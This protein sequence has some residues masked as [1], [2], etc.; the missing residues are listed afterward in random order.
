MGNIV[1]SGTGVFTPSQNLTNEALVAGYNAHVDLWNA[2]H[3]EEIAAGEMTAKEHS[4]EAFIEKASGIKNRY[5]MEASGLEEP[6]R[7]Y[8]YLS[9]L[10]E[11]ELASTP[12]QVKMALAAAKAALSEAGLDGSDIDM[13]IIS[14]S[15][16]ERFVP[17]MATE[18]QQILGANGFAFDMAMGCSSATFGMSTAQDALISGMAN[19]ALVVTAEYLSPLMAYED[20][21]GHFI[22]GDAAVAMILEREEEASSDAAFR[23]LDRK[24]FTEFSTNIQAGFGSRVLIE[25]DKISD[26]AQRFSQSGRVVFKELL[27]KVIDH[28]ESHLGANEKAVSDFKRMW[29]HQA[30]INMNLFASRKIL[31][32]EPSQ[33]EAPTILDQYANTAGAGCMIAFNNH[34]SDFESGDLG[35]I[36]S[37]GASYSIGSF[38]VEKV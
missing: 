12:V 21:D 37:F 33:D 8:P 7:M 32:H 4:S 3:A 2:E 23:I 34:K 18:L 28:V 10:A 11:D 17:S 1:I 24:L 36:C 27:P 30:N 26:P 29:L 19:K 14:A 15:V 20:R 6:D 5:L 22:F 31:G 25:R 9:D 16:W 35:L 38:I 13:V